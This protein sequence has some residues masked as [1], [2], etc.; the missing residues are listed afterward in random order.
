VWTKHRARLARLGHSEVLNP[1]DTGVW[2]SGV[3]EPRGGCQLEV[4]IDG[5]EAFARIAGEI[6][7]AESHVHIAGWHVAPSFELVRGSHPTVLGELLAETAQRVPV[8][9]LV[10]AGSPVPVFHPTR[11]PAR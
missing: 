2:A 4:L 1:R 3:P 8:C 11:R 5:A 10:W 7:R 9:V 6:S